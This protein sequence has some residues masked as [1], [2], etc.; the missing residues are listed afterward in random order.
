MNEILTRVEQSTRQKEKI[1]NSY[2]YLTEEEFQTRKADIRQT[3]NVSGHLEQIQ[4]VYREVSKFL[5][6]AVILYCVSVFKDYASYCRVHVGVVRSGVTFVMRQNLKDRKHR[7]EVVTSMFPEAEA[8]VLGSLE[9]KYPE[10]CRIGV[11][12]KRKIEDWITRGLNI[13]RELEEENAAIQKIKAEYL[14]QLKDEKIVWN[15]KEVYPEGTI[16]RNGLR[17]TFQIIGRRIY[18][19][20]ELSDPYLCKSYS[21]FVKLAENRFTMKP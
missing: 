5:P 7:F 16:T 20:T 9:K 19:K 15:E 2:I 14:A 11:F 13:Y 21:A 1:M 8:T 18:E 12:T 4:P 3:E 17:F 10:P 6:D